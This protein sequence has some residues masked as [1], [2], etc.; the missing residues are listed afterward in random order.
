M[1]LGTL[2]EVPTW[3][4]KADGTL[5][6]DGTVQ[7]IYD[8]ESANPFRGQLILDLSN[9]KSGDYVEVIEYLK[10]LKGGNLGVVTKTQFSGVQEEPIMVFLTKVATYEHKFTLRQIYGDYRTFDWSYQVEEV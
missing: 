10:A 5:M 7:T 8:K 3:K 6:A 4:V 1:G 2:V 9:M